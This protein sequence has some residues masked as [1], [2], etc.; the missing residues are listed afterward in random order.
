MERF[1]QLT[2]EQ[3]HAV[4]CDHKFVDSKHCLKCGWTPPAPRPKD[5]TIAEYWIAFER[6]VIRDELP[7]D[8]QRMLHLAYLAGAISALRVIARAIPERSALVPV[9]S[10]LSAQLAAFAEVWP[11]IAFD[12]GDLPDLE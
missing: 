5:E 2:I 11:P 12:L 9:L 7:T 1:E 8:E 4:K 6:N 10:D 3:E